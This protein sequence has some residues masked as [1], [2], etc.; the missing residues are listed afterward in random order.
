[1]G[2]VGTGKVYPFH[3]ERAAK[4]VECSLDK[5]KV[6]FTVCPSDAMYKNTY[7]FNYCSDILVLSQ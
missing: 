7:N 5:I 1:M 6:Y 4:E 2:M 3:I